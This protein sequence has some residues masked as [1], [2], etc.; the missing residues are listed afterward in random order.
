MKKIRKA[1]FPVAGLGTRFLPATKAI[2]KEMLPIID[3][4]LIEYAVEEAV[5]AGISEIIFITNHTKR[6]IED[7][8][9]QNFEL[10]E[11]L[12]V[13]GKLD[14]IQKINRDLFKD[15]KFTY[16]QQETQKGLG[17]AILQAKD[18][19][20]DEYFAI[21]LADDLVINKAPAIEQLMDIAY[22]KNCSVI[23]LNKVSKNNIHKYGVISSGDSVNESKFFML[24]DIEEKPTKNPP[25]DLAVFGRYILSTNIFQYL[26]DITPGNAG[27]VQL[28]DAIRLM[29]SDHPVSGYLYD[30]LKF[31]C[32]SKEGYVKAISYLSQNI[33]SDH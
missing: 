10:E 9:N 6:S 30:G 27:E 14:E 13:A 32:G 17:D 33:T 23:G 1:V 12:R 26:E 31:D 8:F 3:K 15:I 4:P 24:N 18:V 20:D 25:S 29:L 28:T 2:P 16:I 22:T 5:L 19:I 11:K 21:L 7:H